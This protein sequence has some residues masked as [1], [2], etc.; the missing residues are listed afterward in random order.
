MEAAVAAGLPPVPARG[1]CR[2]G[3]VSRTPKFSL[4][5]RGESTETLRLCSDL[6]GDLTTQ[7]V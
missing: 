5:T 4:S 6:Q 1:S 2:G 7:A 3:S